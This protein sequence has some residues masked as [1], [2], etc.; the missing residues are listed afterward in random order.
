MW[1]GKSLSTST[2]NQSDEDD[3]D[4]SEYGDISGTLEEAEDGEFKDKVSGLYLVI[5]EVRKP[6]P[7]YDTICRAQ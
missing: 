2:I 5:D 4:N 3:S 1:A 7:N 6:T